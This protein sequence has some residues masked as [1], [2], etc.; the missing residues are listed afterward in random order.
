MRID[1]IEPG[2]KNEITH[3]KLEHYYVLIETNCSEVLEAIKWAGSFLYRG[4]KKGTLPAYHGRSRNNRRTAATLPDYQVEID[5]QFLANG[6]TAIRS[7]SIYCTGFIKQ[8]NIYTGREGDNGAIYMVF[9]LNGFSFTWSPKVQ[10]LFSDM[11]RDMAIDERFVPYYEYQDTNLPA[12]IASDNEIMIHG[13]YYA[14]KYESYYEPFA[15][16]YLK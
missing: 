12:A 10:D 2:E 6:F 15:E 5:K 16:R 13:E 4:T 9:P 14:F 1:E 8:A 7:N 3:E 11:R